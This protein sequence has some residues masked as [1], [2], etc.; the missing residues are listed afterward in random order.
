ML[1]ESFQQLVPFSY[2]LVVGLAA[3]AG[4]GALAVAVSAGNARLLASLLV[5]SLAFAG[6]SVTAEHLLPVMAAALVLAAPVLFLTNRRGQAMALVGLALVG[7]FLAIIPEG[8]LAQI[9]RGP[10]SAGFLSLNAS[11]LFTVPTHG[12]F[13]EP[14]LF[15]STVPA[16]Q[17]GVLDPVTWKGFGWVLIAISGSG[18]VAVARGRAGLAA[19]AIAGPDSAAHSRHSSRRTEPMEH[20]ALHPGRT[21]ARRASAG[22]PGDRVVALVVDWSPTSACGSGWP[23]WIGRRHV[24]RKSQPAAW[25]CEDA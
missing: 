12:I 15:T 4:V 9:V 6:M 3:A 2:T 10:A 25:S 5:G 22:N 13:P 17:A 16:P 20:L 1:G 19:P 24:A 8:P 21:S 18:L 23:G 14:S 11:S 7:S